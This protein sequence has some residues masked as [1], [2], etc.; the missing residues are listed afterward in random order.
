[1]FFNP[2]ILALLTSECGATSPMPYP[3]ARPQFVP[4][5]DAHIDSIHAR[6]GWVLAADS[7]GR[8]VARSGLGVGAG[9]GPSPHPC[10]A[11][12]SCSPEAMIS[13]LGWLVYAGGVC[14]VLSTLDRDSAT[15]AERRESHGNDRQ[16]VLTLGYRSVSRSRPQPQSPS[17][18]LDV[19]F[20]FSPGFDAAAGSWSQHTDPAQ[21]AC[22]R[23]HRGSS[24]LGTP[25]S[26]AR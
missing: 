24:S 17:S 14:L 4:A 10:T 26:L 20:G 11:S 23:G 5:R 12:R 16:S 15:R 22:P 8:R 21:A 18:T 19:R 6:S 13:I 1:M 3:A 25:A 9:T 2:R 7:P